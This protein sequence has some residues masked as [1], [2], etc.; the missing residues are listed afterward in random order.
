MEKLFGN[1]LIST[2]NRLYKIKDYNRHSNNRKTKWILISWRDKRC[3]DCGRFIKKTARR[4]NRCE[5]CSKK[6]QKIIKDE[7]RQ[8]NKEY[9]IN[10]YKNN[11]RKKY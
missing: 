3:I 7:W 11:R 1:G 4:G 10:Y 9:F 6:H 2:G 8:N 5:L